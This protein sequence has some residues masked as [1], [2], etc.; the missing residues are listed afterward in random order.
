[1]NALSDKI[2]NHL[3]SGDYIY[4]I[5]LIFLSALYNSRHLLEAYHANRKRRVTDL[6]KIIQSKYISLAFKNSLKE[7]IECEYFKLSFGVRARK[8]LID[9]I[10]QLYE[11]AGHNISLGHFIRATKL[12]PDIVIQRGV[13]QL[14]ISTLD[15]FFAFYNV[16]FGCLFILLGG[17]SLIISI[18]LA[19]VTLGINSLLPSVSMFAGGIYMF[20]MSAPAYSLIIINKALRMLER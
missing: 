5:A 6:E 11:K 7:E 12:V 1:M 2:I 14:K 10:F 16:L 9:K 13:E 4:A 8:S 20:L 19:E 17:F 15:Y 18:T 3:Q